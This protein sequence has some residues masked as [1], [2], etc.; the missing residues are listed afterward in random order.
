MKKWVTP[1][2]VGLLMLSLLTVVFILW[3]AIQKR[4]QKP[5]YEISFIISGKQSPYW[6]AVKQGVD[7]AVSSLT[8]DMSYVTLTNENDSQE[9]ARALLTE[10]SNGAQAVIIAPCPDSEQLLSAIET[11]RRKAVVIEIDSVSGNPAASVT[12]DNTLLGNELAAELFAQRGLEECTLLMPSGVSGALRQR[13]DAFLEFAWK[14]KKRT[15]IQTVDDNFTE[16]D[17]DR[18]MYYVTLDSVTLQTV[19]PLAAGLH[20]DS[21]GLCGIGGN[22]QIAYYLEHDVIDFIVS[23]SAYSLGYLGV[24]MAVGTLG[25][26]RAEKRVLSDYYIISK[27][28]M[29]DSDK[30]RVLFPFVK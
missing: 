29:F 27:E 9:Q 16:A 28:N 22:S 10:I 20:R 11:A 5:V 26:E 8:V 14:M 25:G 12:E 17:L 21:P 13:A 4:S 2:L 3:M 30:Q 7:Q 1:T 18:D 24:R 15:T 19:A 6:D 23:D